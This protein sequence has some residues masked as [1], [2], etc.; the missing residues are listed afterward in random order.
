MVDEL[1]WWTRALADARAAGAG[2]SYGGM[3]SNV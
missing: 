2:R 1:I 3:A